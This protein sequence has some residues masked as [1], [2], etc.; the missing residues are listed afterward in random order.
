MPFG[1]LGKVHQ[2]FRMGV[3]E[4]VAWLCSDAATVAGHTLA[5]DGGMLAR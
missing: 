3:A 1:R 5:L 4:T 2:E